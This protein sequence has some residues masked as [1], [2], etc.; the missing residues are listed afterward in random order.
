MTRTALAAL[1]AFTALPAQ[2]GNV[3][4]QQSCALMAEHVAGILDSRDWNVEAADD[5]AVLNAFS[6]AQGAIITREVAA[7]AA[8][9]SMPVDEVQAMVDA[10]EMQLTAAIVQRYGTDKL[11]RDYGVA[12]LDCAKRTPDN[13]GSPPETFVATLERIGEWAQAG[14]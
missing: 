12:L 14:R 9:L 11:Y 8:Q 5:I 3:T 10:Q 6:A 2:A 1:L 7:S 13:I 4:L